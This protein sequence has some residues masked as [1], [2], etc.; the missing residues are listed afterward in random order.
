[1]PTYW[2]KHPDGSRRSPSLEAIERSAERLPAGTRFE[3]H[4]EYP[5]GRTRLVRSGRPLFGP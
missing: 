3:I 4:V 1:M 2:L 5:D